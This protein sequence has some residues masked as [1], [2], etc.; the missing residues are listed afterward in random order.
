MVGFFSSGPRRSTSLRKPTAAD[1][2]NRKA[3]VE[4]R[5]AARG[6]IKRDERGRKFIEVPN[7]RLDFKEKFLFSGVTKS[8]NVNLKE[9]TAL[10]GPTGIRETMN[11]RGILKKD[12]IGKGFN[13]KV[14][15]GTSTGFLRLGDL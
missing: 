14:G 6:L 1:I 11:V 5:L 13:I 7:S 4:S 9:I 8:G 15:K 3:F 2:A 12:A 10:G